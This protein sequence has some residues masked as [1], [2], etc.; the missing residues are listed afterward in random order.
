MGQ[1]YIEVY[2]TGLT[3][4]SFSVKMQIQ[5]STNLWNFTVRYIA[6]DR[7]FP[8][9]L[10]SFDNVPVNYSR[11]VLTNITVSS[12]NAKTYTNVVNYTE[13]AGAQG[14]TYKTFVPPYTNYQILLFLTSFYINGNN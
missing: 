12:K 11:G 14:Y 1:E 3:T 13:Q 9:N 2:R 7:A 5:G 10:N 8:H 6:I 4:S